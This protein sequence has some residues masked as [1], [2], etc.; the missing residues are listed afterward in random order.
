M[1]VPHLAAGLAAGATNGV[2]AGPL[3][4]HLL[5]DV[6]ALVALV[7]FAY[8][9]RRS[10]AE[11]MFA[12]TVLNL[13][14]FAVLVAISGDAFTAG[15]GFG[16]FGVLSLIRLRSAS[17]TSADMAYAFLVIVVGLVCGLLALPLWVTVSLVG[18]LTLVTAAADHPR[19][20]PP[21]TSRTVVVLD[22]LYPGPAA[23]RADVAARLGVTVVDLEIEEVDF[24]RE[25][26]RVAATFRT[27]GSV[28]AWPALARPREASAGET[29]AA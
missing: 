3:L 15:A 27:G 23:V 2:T 14:L 11:M 9:R 21:Q 20:Q 1:P 25:T 19:W 6:L 12:L 8:R 10:D 22:R 4:T 18:L 24:V 13:G 17:F 5:V 16:L 7:G 26:T 29:G 28:G